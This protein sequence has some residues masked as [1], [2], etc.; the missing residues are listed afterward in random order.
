MATK[1]TEEVTIRNFD[2]L[3]T[4]IRIVGDSPHGVARLGDA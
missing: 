2:Q 1:K 4:K 3:T